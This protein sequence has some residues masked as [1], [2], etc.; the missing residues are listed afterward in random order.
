MKEINSYVTQSFSVIVL[1]KKK[2]PG[3][4]LIKREERKM[5]FANLLE[6]QF[7]LGKYTSLTVKL[8]CTSCASRRQSELLNL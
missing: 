2:W 5:S 3:E 7:N 4:N 1:K 6:F 8:C